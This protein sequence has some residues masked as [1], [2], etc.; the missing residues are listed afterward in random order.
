MAAKHETKF[1]TLLMQDAETRRDYWKLHLETQRH[2]LQCATRRGPEFANLKV[3]VEAII[4]ECETR[5]RIVEQEIQKMMPQYEAAMQLR[6]QELALEE[7]RRKAA[8]QAQLCVS[9]RELRKGDTV[10]ID[11]VPCKIE[12]IRKPSSSKY[13]SRKRLIQ[14]RSLLWSLERADELKHPRV[15][16][17]FQNSEH[18]FRAVCHR[19]TLDVIK[20]SLQEGIQVYNNDCMLETFPVPLLDDGTPSQYFVEL[21]AKVSENQDPGKWWTLDVLRVSA[22]GLPGILQTVF[23]AQYSVV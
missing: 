22:P 2:E 14:A 21:V 5:L 9:A 3:L 1:D 20:A 8:I 10:W 6:R 4:T 16:R 7:S 19:S 23:L 18:V 13:P 15:E 12:D 17:W 11:G